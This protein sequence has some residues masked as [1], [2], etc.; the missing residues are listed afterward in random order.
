MH[1]CAGSRPCR[2]IL[3]HGE[4][5]AEALHSKQFSPQ[6]ALS[7]LRTYSDNIGITYYPRRSAG[8]AFP[9]SRSSS[10]CRSSA[11][12]SSRDH[13]NRVL[14]NASSFE[15]A[16]SRFTSLCSLCGTSKPPLRSLGQPAHRLLQHLPSRLQSVPAHPLRGSS[17]QL[18]LSLCLGGAA[19]AAAAQNAP[20]PSGSNLLHSGL[21]GLLVAAANLGRQKVSPQAPLAKYLSDR[22]GDGQRSGY[23]APCHHHRQHC[24]RT[25]QTDS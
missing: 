10:N 7:Y 3:R 15:D 16:V 8:I 19:A 20:G 13:P 25:G 14:S 5:L 2:C 21:Q 23:A 24:H 1:L 9:Q 18:Q 17:L 4:S 11:I 12:F 6:H 22:I